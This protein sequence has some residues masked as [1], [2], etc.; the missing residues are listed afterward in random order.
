MIMKALGHDFSSRFLRHTILISPMT[1]DNTVAALIIQL[2]SAAYKLCDC[3][4][5]EINVRS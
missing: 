1:L 5:F 3:V 4:R 2:I